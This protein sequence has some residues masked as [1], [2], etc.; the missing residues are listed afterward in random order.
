MGHAA[1]AGTTPKRHFREVRLAAKPSLTLGSRVNVEVFNGVQ[2]VD[3]IGTSKGKGFAGVMK[4]Y[5]F[6]GQ[7]GSHGTE[8]KHRSR[9][10]I[11]SR[12]TWRGQCGKPAAG[13]KMAGHMGSDQVTCRN[14][15]LVRIDKDNDV[16]LIKGALPGA[17]G[18]VVYIR[19]SI[20]A[21]PIVEKP[22]EEDTADKKKKK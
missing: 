5:L 13:M 15:L 4:R 20:T 9:G 2:F 3:V 22:K 12:A 18:S 17:N 6:G 19:K 21:R 1:K 16:L 14:Q 11:A 8:R 10:S 7:P